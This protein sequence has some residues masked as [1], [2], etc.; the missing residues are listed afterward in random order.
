MTHRTAQKEVL[1]S[2]ST[3]LKILQAILKKIT[4]Q[5]GLKEAYMERIE[6]FEASDDEMMTNRIRFRKYF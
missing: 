1:K 5:S 4:A 3:Q 2:Q 6:E